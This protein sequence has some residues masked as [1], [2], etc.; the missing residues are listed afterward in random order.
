MEI[1]Y[2]GFKSASYSTVRLLRTVCEVLARWA[3]VV[4]VDEGEDGA[5]GFDVGFVAER[6]HVAGKLK[7]LH[8][9]ELTF[10]KFFNFHVFSC[11]IG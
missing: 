7:M 9:L 10:F 3:I 6:C 5:H 8:V 1:L 2:S 11:L 4:L